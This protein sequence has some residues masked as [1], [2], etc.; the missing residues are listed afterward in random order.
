MKKIL[1]ILHYPPPVHGAA[2]VGRQIRESTCINDTFECKYINLGLSVSIN[3]IGKGGGQKWIR[4]F[5][6]LR[7]TIA[8]LLKYRP[9]LVYLTLT[10]YGSGF[11]KDAIVALLV[12]SFRV[13]VVYHFHNKGVSTRQD[14]WLDDLV[15][16][17][18][19]RNS[20]VILLSPNLYSDIKKYVPKERVSYC[21]N[22]V[23][24][25]Y[26]RADIPKGEIENDKVQ[27][28][29]LSNLLKTKG[30]YV[31]LEACQQLKT[32]SIPFQCT[33]IGGAGDIPEKEFKEK[34]NLLELNDSVEYLGKKYGKEK[35][36]AYLLADIFAF[37]TYNETFGLVILEAMKYSLPVVST[38]E[39]G[40]PDIISD[41]DTGFLV[42]P[43]DAVAFADKLETL[44]KDRKLRL[45]MGKRGRRRF[46]ENYTI[47]AFER[48]F[49]SILEKLI[50]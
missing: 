32:R 36:R 35:E 21:A 6:I 25:E 23:S 34:I 12:K 5:T 17:L 16:K 1:F 27:I 30:V 14:R 41:G 31:L 20:D 8:H 49:V 2:V 46:E 38:E 19:F 43:Q 45:C 50:Y 3:E 37:P 7:L 47:E 40:I 42:R 29:F 22:G 44:I 24:K 10:S 26:N 28:L 15:Y 13:K 33:F 48:R 9:D 18:V 39:G 11:F 4:Y